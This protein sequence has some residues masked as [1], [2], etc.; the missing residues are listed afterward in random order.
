MFFPALHRMATFGFVTFA[1]PVRTLTSFLTPDQQ[2][3]LIRLDGLGK[4]TL[5]T[6]SALYHLTSSRLV[7]RKNKNLI[8][9]IIKSKTDH[10]VK[11][12]PDIMTSVETENVLKLIDD[13]FQGI[14]LYTVCSFNVERD[15][16]SF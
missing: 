15:H 8:K 11:I 6:L 13:R 2:D 3:S 14:A 7:N 12:Q 9:N 5:P 16:V 1:T 10:G 4:I